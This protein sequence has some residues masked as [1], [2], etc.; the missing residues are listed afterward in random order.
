MKVRLG[1]EYEVEDLGVIPLRGK[2]EGMKLY[3]VELAQYGEGAQ[4]V[5]D[6]VV[7]TGAWDGSPPA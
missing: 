4:I 1:S 3:A 7:E 2:A 6:A 5:R